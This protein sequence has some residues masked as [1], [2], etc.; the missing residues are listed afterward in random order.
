MENRSFDHFLGWL[1]GARRQAGRADLHRPLRRA[2]P[3]PPPDRL[4]QG[5]GHPDPDHSYE[6]GRIQ[7]N[8]GRCDGWLRAGRERPV[9]RSATTPTPT[10]R[11]SARR[12]AT[13][14]CAT[15]LLRDHGRDLPE[16]L[17]PARRADRP[18]PQLD[19][20]S[21]RCRRSGTGSRRRGDRARYYF[22]DVPFPALWGTQ[23]PRH[24]QARSRS[25]SPTPQPAPC[26]RCRFVDPR[27]QDEGAG[28]SRD[29]H[30]HAD[31]RAG[32][33]FLDQVYDAVTTGPTGTA[34]CWSST[35]TSGA[36]ST[37][38][39]PPATRPTLTPNG[40][41]R[42][43]RVPAWSSRRS[44][45]AATSP[46]NVYDHTSVLKMI[47]WR[48]GLPALT[49]RDAAARNLAEVL[50]FT[51]APNAQRPAYAV[52][53]FVG[54][55]ACP[56]AGPA[57]LRGLARRS[58]TSPSPHGW[59]LPMTR[60]APLASPRRPPSAAR[61]VGLAATTASSLGRRQPR[62]R[63]GSASPR[64]PPAGQARVRHQHREQG[65]RRDVGSPASAAPYLAQTLR[66]QGQSCSTQYYGTAHNSLPQLR[67]ADLR[68]GPE[69]ADA[70]RLPGL[71]ATS[72]APAPRRPAGRRRRAASSP[73]RCPPWPASSTRAGLTWRGYMEDM[74]TPCRHPALGAQDDTQKAKVGDQ[75]ATRHNPFMYFHS[76]IDDPAYCA[77]HVVDLDRADHRPG[78]GARPRG[79]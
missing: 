67:R 59:S 25:S 48:W 62:P 51:S 47:E 31:I 33:Q 68:A 52:P 38:T 27:F 2:A 44:P 13:G 74:G 6:G 49:P 64:L 5:C 56:P 70:G 15:V 54:R 35:T 19:R 57:G 16:P 7:F 75:Y 4:R 32:E 79:T 1:P 9:R 60:T 72:P 18:A 23:V 26:R 50:D 71:H 65:L 11:S 53:P 10:W 8:G 14:R 63:R 30:P 12:P 55:P 34:P 61:L 69:P 41:M 17:L 76:I 77:A 37:T 45:A 43:F 78:D 28:T 39:S 58:R 46:T 40:R 73:P 24:L 20:R 29:D 42:G 22:S 3:H 66:A 21:R 36:A